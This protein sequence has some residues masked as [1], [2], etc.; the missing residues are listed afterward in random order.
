MTVSLY[1][2]KASTFEK[3]ANIVRY[4]KEKQ[5]RADDTELIWI[6]SDKQQYLSGKKYTIN[7]RI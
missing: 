5:Y 6:L 3:L 4:L 7:S 2:K 1:L